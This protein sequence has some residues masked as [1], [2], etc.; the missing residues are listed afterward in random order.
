MEESNPTNRINTSCLPTTSSNKTLA[1]ILNHARS[2][3]R[4]IP[5]HDSG[6]YA[7]YKTCLKVVLRAALHHAEKKLLAT[8]GLASI[9]VKSDSLTIN[10]CQNSQSKLSQQDLEDLQRSTK[11]DKKEIQQWYKGLSKSI[12]YK[13]IA[14][15][16]LTLF[17]C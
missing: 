6:S 13:S 17:V 12:S 8:S 2:R 10:H 16:L 15:S 9:I 3:P 4:H 5:R 11:F 7:E 14:H 1:P